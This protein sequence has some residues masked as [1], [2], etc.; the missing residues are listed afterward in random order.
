MKTMA[1]K[2]KI[3]GTAAAVTPILLEVFLSFTALPVQAQPRSD[4]HVVVISLDGFGAQALQNPHLPLPNLRKLI[5][6]GAYSTAML[7]INPTVTWPNHTAIVTGVDASVHG[8]LYNGLPV[9][10]DSK[11][12]IDESVDKA[13]LVHATTVYD[14]AFRAG[15]TTAEVDWVAIQNP[16]TITWSFAEE[17]SAEGAVE[18]ELGAAGVVNADQMRTFPKLP[19]TERDEH[20]QNAAIQILKAHKPNLMLLHFLTT[21]TVQH[22][23]APNTLATDTALVLADQRVGRVLQAIREIGIE[24]RTTIIV[25]SDHGFKT[26]RKVIHPRS[27]LRNQGSDV[28]VVPEGGTAMVYIMNSAKRTSLL[29]SLPQQFGAIEGIARVITSAQFPEFGYPA[30]E[31]NEGMADLVLV[32]SDGYAFDGKSDGE[33]VSESVPPVGSHG[34][35]NT[36]PDMNAI[37]IAWGAGIRKGIQMPEIRNVDV[38]PTIARLLGIEM[39]GVSGHALANVLE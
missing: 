38:A 12:E 24:K 33:P 4:S 34:Y 39:S 2:N 15:L 32:A 26:V 23:Y 7:P 30:P 36:D 17:P 3:C 37:F 10:K 18:R 13:N 14:L 16:G 27:I 1:L 31:K 6:E 25:V 8:V 19:I 28:F 22:R 11:M 9:R 35:L 29:H 5:A 21:D 20:W